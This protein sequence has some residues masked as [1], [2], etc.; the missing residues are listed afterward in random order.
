VI[1]TKCGERNEPV[2]LFFEHGP[3]LI[4]AILGTL[5]AGKIYVS[6]DPL[7]PQALNKEALLDSTA[8]LII[9]F[10]RSFA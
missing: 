2:I 10:L 1:L 8:K 4:A 3:L 5:K 6:L 7:Q 9:L